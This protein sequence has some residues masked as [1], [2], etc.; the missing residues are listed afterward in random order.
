MQR[1]TKKVTN[2][3]MRQERALT[4][5][6][7]I[8]KKVFAS[9]QNS[10]ILTGFINDILELGATDV[11]I[12]NTYN[13]NTFHRRNENS[14]IKSTQVDV[15]ARLEDG[16][17]VTIEMQVVQQRLFRKRAFFYATDIYRSNYD[18]R[19]LVD[20]KGRQTK[21]EKKYSS[22]RPVYS[23]CIM[24]ENEFFE[25]ENPIHEFRMYDVKNDI[26]Y[27][28][29]SGQDMIR[30]TFLEIKKSSNE[31]RENIKAWFEYF[32]TGNVTDNAPRYIQE[33]CAIASY[34]N[35]S[36]EEVSMIS[37]MQR[38]IDATQDREDYVWYSGKEEG[39]AE[40][41][42]MLVRT[43]FSKGKTIEEIAGLTDMKEDEVR[44]I[45]K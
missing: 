1:E 30:I 41:I 15:L 45:V 43:L 3:V 23:I 29:E 32:N 8:F 17:Q 7:L 36:S 34:K 10:H 38:A 35:L 25:D 11:T 14:E 9:P 40:G 19:S 12:E 21:A 44:E 27:I 20:T 26:F 24:A 2:Q 37:E 42:A 6:D 5:N 18:K 22:L 39:I 31:M 13:I 4:T 16:S 28:D 33:A